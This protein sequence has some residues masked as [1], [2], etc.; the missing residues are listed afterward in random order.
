MRIAT[1]PK[2]SESPEAYSLVT[3][4]IVCRTGQFSMRTLDALMKEKKIR[5]LK[6]GRAVRFYLP[7]VM[8]DLMR[9]ERKAIG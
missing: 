2:V 5:F 6:I 8:E 4:P 3:K 1:Q 7:H 9:Y